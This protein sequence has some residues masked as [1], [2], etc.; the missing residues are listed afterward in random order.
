MYSPGHDAQPAVPPGWSYNPS[1]WSERLWLVGVALVGLAVSSYLAFYQFG[2][3]SA[4]W[5]P[6]FGDGS[7]QVL[8]SVLSRLLPL[9]DAALGAAAYA[10]D[11]VAGVIGRQDRW[12]SMPWMVILFGLAVGPLGLVSVLLVIAQPVVLQAWCTLCLVSAVASLVMIGP[13]MDEVLASLQF[14]R[15]CHD[16]DRSLWTTFWRG[17]AQELC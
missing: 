7:A 4:V 12:R 3:L 1:A 14:L 13:A 16:R 5:E 10:L 2:W 9:P 6:F 15:R 8:H 11:A 17:D